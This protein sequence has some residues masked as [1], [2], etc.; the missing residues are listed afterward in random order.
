MTLTRVDD[1]FSRQI[2]W[3]KIAGTVTRTETHGNELW[4]KCTISFESATDYDQEDAYDGF[5]NIPK[6]DINIT[7]GSYILHTSSYG[8]EGNTYTYSFDG[9]TNFRGQITVKAPGEE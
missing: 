5:F 7:S 4:D 6:S 8:S 9:G 1:P 2:V 3:F